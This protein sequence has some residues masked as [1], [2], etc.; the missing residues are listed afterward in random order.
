[1]KPAPSLE[2]FEMLPGIVALTHGLLLLERTRTLVVADAHLAYEDAIGGAL[3][4]WST[5]E[6]LAVLSAAIARSGARELVM[7]GDIIHSSRLSEGAAQAVARTLDSLRECVELVLVAGNHEGRSRG[8]NVLGTT[9]EAVER[10][11]WLL[12]HG[13][14]TATLSDRPP[15]LIVGHL[16]PSIPLARGESVPA[17][18]CSRN[19]I[20]VPALTPYSL[21]LNA[22]G[23]DCTKALRGFGART[24][25]VSVVAST[26][27][28]VYPFGRLSALRTAL[29]PARG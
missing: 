22:L 26:A 16:H 10:D 7:L 28:R 8:R 17:F 2:R 1:M 15:R 27:E 9:V 6:S 23:E 25:D 11:G 12:V 29:R 14:E 21:G 19:L 24:H 20:V 4:L 5:A 3:P 13:D 18:L